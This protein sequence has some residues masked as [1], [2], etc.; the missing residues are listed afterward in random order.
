MTC[1]GPVYRSIV[2]IQGAISAGAMAA[3]A[4]TNPVAST[5]PA[6]QWRRNPMSVSWVWLV[7]VE[8]FMTFDHSSGDSLA[9]AAA[10]LQGYN[11]TL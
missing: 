8:V 9:V 5:A 3:G 6:R 4:A 2:G 1:Q 7:S 10:S 11:R